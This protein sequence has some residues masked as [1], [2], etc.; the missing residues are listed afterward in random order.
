MS[1]PPKPCLDEKSPNGSEVERVDIMQ[2]GGVDAEEEEPAQHIHAKTLVLLIVR[3][4][5]SGIVLE[6]PEMTD[7]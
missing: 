2:P 4:A 1:E 7:F 5:Q 6:Q 3:R